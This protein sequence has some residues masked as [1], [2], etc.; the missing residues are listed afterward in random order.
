MTF[1]NNDA[2]RGTRSHRYKLCIETETS[3]TRSFFK[4][5]VYEYTVSNLRG[6][7]A[8]QSYS[9]NRF[10]KFHNFIP[11]KVYNRSLPSKNDID[12]PKYK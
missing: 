5:N 2:L 4:C 11:S 8:F 7:G 1:E 6:R 10:D 12:L 3:N 9:Y